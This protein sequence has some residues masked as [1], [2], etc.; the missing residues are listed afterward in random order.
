VFSFVFF[1]AQLSPD[2]YFLKK[3]WLL[4]QMEKEGV[5]HLKSPTV[6]LGALLLFLCELSSAFYFFKNPDYQY[7]GREKEGGFKFKIP[8]KLG[9]FGGRVLPPVFLLSMNFHQILT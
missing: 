8:L 1:P 3:P 4:I 5:F 9:F 7:K 2:F 6:H